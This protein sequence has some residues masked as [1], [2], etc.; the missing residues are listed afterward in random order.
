MGRG[1]GLT[2]NGAEIPHGPQQQLKPGDRLHMALPGGGGYGSPLERDVTKV[3][4]DVQQGYVTSACALSDYGVVFDSA[5]RVD[6]AATR[7]ERA[8]RLKQTVR[9]SDEAHAPGL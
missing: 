9:G 1:E 4:R 5:G 7:R 3:A 8:G 6:E 2:L